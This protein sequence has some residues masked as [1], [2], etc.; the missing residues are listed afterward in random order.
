M[1]DPKLKTL[2]FQQMHPMQIEAMHDIVST[3]LSLA[4]MAED[5]EILEEVETQC[6]EFV[7]LFGG[8]GVTVNIE[9]H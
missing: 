6:D 7:R 8:V 3:A 5:D 2:G 9:H 4:A 1:I